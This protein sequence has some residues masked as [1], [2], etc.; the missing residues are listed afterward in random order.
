MV[1][2]HVAGG[3]DAVVVPGP[4]ADPDV[5]GHGDLDVVDVSAVPD[6]LVH[7]VGEPQRQDVLHRLLAEVVI[8][9]EH[10]LGREDP[11]QR[12]V[13]LPRAGQVVAERLLDHHPPP[14][15]PVRVRQAAALE[16]LDHGGKLVRRDRQVER[17]VPARAPLRV[18]LAHALGEL[19]ERRVVA[20][21]PG[22]EPDALAELLPHRV[23]ERRARVLLHR[24]VGD[25]G[26][27][28]VRPVPP[29]EADE[30]EA[31][32]QQAPVGQVVDRRH[33]LLAREVT[34]DPEH[35]Q[36][37]RPCHPRDAPVPRIAQRVSRL[38]RRVDFRDDARAGR[39]QPFDFCR[40]PSPIFVLI[41]SS[42]WVHDASNFCTP[43]S[44]RT[45][46]TSSYPMPSFS[47]SAKTCRDAS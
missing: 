25:L 35:D 3:S 19:V 30:R 33:Q 14:A 13:Q 23:T 45:C 29:G 5:L 31:W 43:S 18:E 16:L 42:S 27:I 26:E 22:H 44:S 47:R 40:H 6:R 38:G 2:D 28:L 37:A 32:R 12:R 39:G 8:D 36:Y 20:E 9:A 15:A 11:V 41:V 4:A 7:L 1:L 21:R 17:V 10:R 46:T 34:G 24:L